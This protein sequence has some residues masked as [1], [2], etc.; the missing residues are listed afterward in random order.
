MAQILSVK[1][2]TILQ[3]ISSNDNILVILGHRLYFKYR[4]DKN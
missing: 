4:L 1:P 3:K 2:Y